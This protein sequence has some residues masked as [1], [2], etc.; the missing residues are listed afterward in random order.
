MKNLVILLSFKKLSPA[1]LG[2]FAKAILLAMTGNANF[3]NP[4]P[5]LNLLQA[6]IL[7]LS[8]AVDAQ[9]HG[10][11]ATTA[12]VTKAKRD[13]NRLLTALAAYVVY[14]S[15]DDDVKALTSGFSLQGPPQAQSNTFTATQGVQ[16]GT[17]DVDSPAIPGGGAFI[18][19]HTADPL[20]TP[21]WI[22]DATTVYSSYT[23]TGLN[24][25]TK[26]WFRVALV[27]TEGQQ[28]FG[29]PIMVHVV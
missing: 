6:A 12:A 7:A 16:S 14:E 13:L 8:N 29:D 22:V 11:P 20:S 4:Y 21:N 9:I 23:V 2:V 5:A 24:P 26:Y 19:E 1:N 17:V 28:P 15:D 25:G 3:P 27:T 18:F 10:V